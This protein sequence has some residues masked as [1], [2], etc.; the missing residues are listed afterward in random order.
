MVRASKTGRSVPNH[1]SLSKL[2]I[3]PWLRPA[4]SK[5]QRKSFAFSPDVTQRLKRLTSITRLES[6]SSVIRLALV[7]LEDLVEATAKGEKIVVG[8]KNY[9]P[10]VRP[11]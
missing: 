6:D 4:G 11:Q 5:M 10:F 2:H 7:V 3:T 8:E 9:S 1:K